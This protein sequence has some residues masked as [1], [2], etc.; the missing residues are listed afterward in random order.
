[1]LKHIRV[2]GEFASSG[3]LHFLE[4]S[5]SISDSTRKGKCLCR[6]L[7]CLICKSMRMCRVLYPD[8]FA[9]AGVDM[10]QLE[11]ILDSLELHARGMQ[12]TIHSLCA[13]LRSSAAAAAPG[14]PTVKPQMSPQ[15]AALSPA[16]HWWPLLLAFMLGCCLG[17]FCGP[18]FM[19]RRL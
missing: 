15:W 8:C 13:A 2:S 1:V 9:F 12:E 5:C 7:I 19:Y 18:R 4:H 14:G 17:A 16:G 10:E 3:V 6:R 11:P